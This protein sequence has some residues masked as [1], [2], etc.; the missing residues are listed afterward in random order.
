MDRRKQVILYVVLVLAGLMVGYWYGYGRG[1]NAGYKRAEV[2]IKK[3]DTI[4]AQKA[5][6]EAA[7]VANP[8]QAVNP[9]SGVE[10]NPF[11]KAKKILNPFK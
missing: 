9:L 1:D 5:T 4:V 2:D 7:K 8:F 6:E 10:A 3:L 11:E